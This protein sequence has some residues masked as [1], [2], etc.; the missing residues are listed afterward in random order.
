MSN[1]L[2]SSTNRERERE[3]E[4]DYAPNVEYLFLE[5]TDRGTEFNNG[6][7]VDKQFAAD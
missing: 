2:L 1:I 4:R 5:S 3:R 6:Y 7:F